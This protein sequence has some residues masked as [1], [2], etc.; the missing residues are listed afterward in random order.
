MES[1][2]EFVVV[3][4]GSVEQLVGEGDHHQRRP[5]VSCCPQGQ[6]MFFCR[7]NIVMM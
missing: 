3:V 7:W 1:V 2:E 4:E 6:F 5:G